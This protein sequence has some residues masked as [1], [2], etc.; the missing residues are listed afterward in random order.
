MICGIYFLYVYFF[1]GF[2][3]EYVEC[4]VGLFC[5]DDVVDQGRVFV[6]GFMGYSLFDD[7]FLIVFV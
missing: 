7:E 5:R 2:C 1:D 3:D 6:N 4:K